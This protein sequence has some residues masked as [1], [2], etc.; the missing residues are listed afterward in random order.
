MTSLV[1]INTFK[2]YLLSGK[3]KHSPSHV[4]NILQ[5]IQRERFWGGGNG[6]RLRC[7]SRAGMRLF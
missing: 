1:I 2:L 4:G 5:V 6:L 3:R 7:G